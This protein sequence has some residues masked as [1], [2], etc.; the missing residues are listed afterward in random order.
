[1]V[2]E[3]GD[4]RT[5][6]G[7]HSFA[8]VIT[9]RR[10]IAH[11]SWTDVG[12]ATFG[13]VL[14]LAMICLLPSCS[15][16]GPPAIHA[17]DPLAQGHGTNACDLLTD[18]EIQRAISAHDSGRPNVSELTGKSVMTN[19]WGFQSCRWTATTAQ[20]IQGFPNGWFDK[21]ELK[22]FDK[23]RSSA[24]RKEAEGEPLKAFGEQARYDA[25]NG[26]IWFN[27][28][29]GQFCM[30]NAETANGEKRE[31]LASDLA[32]LVRSRLK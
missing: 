30:L 10:R 9:M 27:C 6:M 15:K 2:L 20:K 11:V 32:S 1:M 21:I 12:P 8:E 17:Q 23:E 7:R 16:S 18:D 25:T 24:A 3:L 22:V 26:R 14:L 13:A 19:M 29:D 31:Q 5:E 4:A 28:G